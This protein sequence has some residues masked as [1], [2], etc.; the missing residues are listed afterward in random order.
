[1]GDRSR[2]TFLQMGAH[3]SATSL[4]MPSL[5][6][7]EP[8]TGF[9][10][11]AD[12]EPVDRDFERGDGKEYT[13]LNGYKTGAINNLS[14]PVHGLGSGGAGDGTSSSALL[15]AIP[16]NIL[17]MLMG[18]APSNYTGEATSASQADEDTVTADAAYTDVVAGA[19]VAVKGADSDLLHARFVSAVSSADATVTPNL[20]QRDGTVENAKASD[21]VYGMRVWALNEAT[22]DVTPLAA[23]VEGPNHRRQYKNGTGSFTL[24]LPS[25]GFASLAG[26]LEFSD[27]EDVAEANPTFSAPTQGGH[28]RVID[29]PLYIG[30]SLYMAS[31][32][33][34]D[35]GVT[36]EPRESDGAPNGKFGQVATRTQPVLTARLASGTLTTPNEVTDAF[37][38]TLQ[39]TQTAVKT[40]QAVFL[41]VGRTVGAVMGI[42][43][44][45]A[46]VRARRVRNGGQYAIQAEFRAT[47]HATLASLYVGIG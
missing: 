19:M 31:N 44:P 41:Q 5:V 32:M 12:F 15:T 4:A 36:F 37:L 26:S 27:W 35:F 34:L 33:S 46:E 18:A 24:N 3:A 14:V 16:T 6:F 38:A 22:G 10:D 40:P 17:T 13:S 47:R 30:D 2:N 21:I 25:G 23:D 29:S 1:M 45:A 8:V 43:M 7:V 42:Y 9:E 39:G 20:T 28:V 11:V